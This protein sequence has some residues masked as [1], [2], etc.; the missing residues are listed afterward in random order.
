M[1]ICID[2]VHRYRSIYRKIYLLDADYGCNWEYGVDAHWSVLN[3]APAQKAVQEAYCQ[4][5]VVLIAA[6]LSAIMKQGP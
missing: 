4:G 5:H 6:I 1:D 3:T 2:K